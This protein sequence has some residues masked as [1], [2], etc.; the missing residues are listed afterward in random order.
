MEKEDN[1]RQRIIKLARERFYAIGFSKVT[2]DEL[3]SELGIGKRTIYQHFRS[4]NDLLDAVMEWQSTSIKSQTAGILQESTDFVDRIYRM[5]ANVGQRVSQVGKQFQDDIR[6]FRPDLWERVSENR[7][8]FIL[9]NFSKMIDEGIRQGFIRSDINKDIMVLMY[10]ASI[11]MIVNP[12]VVA[13]HSFTGQEA[14]QSILKVYFDGILTDG[15]REHF[16]EKILQH[17]TLE[18]E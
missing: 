1:L 18:K 16:H 3:A 9:G 4:K 11:Q 6:K 10:L 15:A 13:Q 2:M 17:Q 14:M 7:K 12:E 8:E 5:L